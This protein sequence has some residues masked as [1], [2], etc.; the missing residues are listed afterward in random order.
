MYKC[1]CVCVPTIDSNDRCSVDKRI[2]DCLS[3]EFNTART[4]VQRY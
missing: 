1:V 3:I 2:Y 4:D